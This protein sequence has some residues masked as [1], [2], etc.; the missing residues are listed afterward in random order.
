MCPD[1][2]D[3][4]S[5]DAPAGPF[6]ANLDQPI[7]GL[8]LGLP[9]QYLSDAN[10]PSVAGAIDEAVEVFRGLGAQIVEVDLPHTE[11]G[12]AT[13]YIVA[14]AEASSNLARYDGVRYG[15]RADDTADMIDLYCRSRSQGFG[16]E[17]KRRIML[18]TY[19]LSSGYYDA[20]YLRALKV[21]RL[22]KQD[23]DGAFE[24]CDAILCPTSTGPAFKIGEKT[25]NPLAMYLNDIYTATANLAG[26]PGISIPVFDEARLLRIARMYEAATHHHLARPELAQA[27]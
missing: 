7:D 24:K 5:V 14:T 11:Y 4:T 2:L 9:N 23:F 20:Y 19:A 18:G 21:R 10:H 6:H 13:Y 22:I 16:D 27:D 3:S 12:I 1:P 26:I 15:R 25:S 17:V 8:R